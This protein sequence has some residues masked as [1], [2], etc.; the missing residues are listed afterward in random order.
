MSG[1]K[2]SWTRKRKA[3]GWSTSCHCLWKTFP[4]LFYWYN[5][6]REILRKCVFIPSSP[7]TDCRSV[8]SALLRASFCFTRRVRFDTFSC[9]VHQ[10]ENVSYLSTF[11]QGLDDKRQFRWQARSAFVCNCKPVVFREAK[12]LISVTKNALNVSNICCWKEAACQNLWQGNYCSLCFRNRTTT[13]AS[14]VVLTDPTKYWRTHAFSR[15]RGRARTYY[16]YP[17]ITILCNRDLRAQ[18]PLMLRNVT[19]PTL[20]YRPPSHHKHSQRSSL[21][22]FARPWEERP[23]ALSWPCISLSPMLHNK[24]DYCSI[25]H[26][27]DCICIFTVKK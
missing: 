13:S 16:P 5:R 10:K 19:K 25:F 18:M 11:I 9:T 17:H 14:A 22:F 7:R 15:L 24:E 6:K 1:H 26:I 20:M 23:L 12:A 4:A 3:T 2:T 27:V 8:F 21:T